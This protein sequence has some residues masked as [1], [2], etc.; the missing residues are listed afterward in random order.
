MLHLKPRLTGKV[1]E[2][3]ADARVL[4]EMMG[5]PSPH[6]LHLF[7]VLAVRHDTLSAVVF[8]SFGLEP[9]KLT[10]AGLQEALRVH[11]S[12]SASETVFASSLAQALNS[13]ADVAARSE[14]DHISVAHLTAALLESGTFT[15]P[16]AKSVG[17]DGGRVANAIEFTARHSGR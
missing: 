17:L 9:W 12:E 6:D 5:D 14:S 1:E 4:A 3:L 2:A 7:T 8:K 11:R 13:A 16:F 15:A 10:G